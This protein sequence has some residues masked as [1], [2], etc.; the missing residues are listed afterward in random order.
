MCHWC[1]AL[2]D[3]HRS[4]PIIHHRREPLG[5]RHRRHRQDLDN[6]DAYAVLAHRGACESYKA[7]LR[8]TVGWTVTVRQGAGSRATVLTST[9]TEAFVRST[10]ANVRTW[11]FDNGLDTI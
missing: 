10:L 7:R 9:G 3:E 8:A 2:R 5:Q 1:T 4:R 11:G 6:L